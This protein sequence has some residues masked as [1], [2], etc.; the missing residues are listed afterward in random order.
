MQCDALV[1]F[2]A[3]R[4][5][6]PQVVVEAFSPSAAQRDLL[7]KVR[8]QFRT[9]SVTHHMIVGADARQGLRHARAPSEAVVVVLTLDPPGIEIDIASVF[10]GLPPPA[11]DGS[12]APDS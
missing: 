7:A 5:E 4:L 3:R 9:P 10:E 11:G 6:A 2:D 1:V 12:A 8:D